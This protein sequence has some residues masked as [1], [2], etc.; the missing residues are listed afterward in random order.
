MAMP[1]ASKA[2]HGPLRAA[3]RKRRRRAGDAF[4]TELRQRFDDCAESGFLKHAQVRKVILGAVKDAVLRPGDP[5]PSEKE[6][7][8][9]LGVSLGTVQRALGHL[10]N[11]G[12]IVREHG[13]GSFIA[14]EPRAFFR[15]LSEDGRS[16]MP[17]SSRVLDRRIVHKDG[18][19]SDTLG[20]DPEGYVRISR[21]FN[22]DGRFHCYSEFY[23]AAGRFGGMMDHPLGEDARLKKILGEEFQTPVLRV[24]QRVRAET[25]SPKICRLINAERG[26]FGFL[27]EIVSYT[28]DDQAVCYQE[29]W[30]PATPYKLDLSVMD[31]TPRSSPGPRPGQAEQGAS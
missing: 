28:F 18:P 14:D 8:D 9:I 19:W 21:S 2:A 11:E 17:V 6:L 24:W 13:R 5:I 23:L 1:T 16:V 29:N 12:V 15:F 7:T 3:P 26:T 31:W 27:V 10:V 4:A 30:I 25:L 20:E 22:I